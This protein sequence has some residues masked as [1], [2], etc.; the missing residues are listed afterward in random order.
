MSHLGFVERHVPYPL[1]AAKLSISFTLF[2]WWRPFFQWNRRLT[3][4]AKREGTPIWYVRWL[5]IQISY[6]RWV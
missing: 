1:R 4:A 5:F 6:A 2:P 3:E